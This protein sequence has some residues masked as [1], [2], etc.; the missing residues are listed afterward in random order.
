M[1]SCARVKGL[2]TSGCE[3]RPGKPPEEPGSQPPASG[4]ILASKRGEAKLQ[5]ATT[6]NSAASKRS[7]REGR[8][9]RA[10]E[11]RAKAAGRAWDS[12]AARNCTGVE[13]AACSEGRSVNW[14][15]PPAPAVERPGSMPW[16]KATPKSG[17]VRRESE[18]AIVPK[19]V[20]TTEL[21]VGKAPHFGD[22]RAARGGSGH[23]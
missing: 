3:S 5:A 20:E 17:A 19:I 11:V 22:A 13:E 9:G 10:W 16:Y 15:G 23:G 14:G 4:E 1:T 6:V 18:R 12:G 7:T 21:G 2:P 8:A